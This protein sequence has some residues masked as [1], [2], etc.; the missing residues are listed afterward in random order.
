MKD[1]S[2]NLALA[3]SA[4]VRA[5]GTSDRLFRAA[6]GLILLVAAALVLITLGVVP[7]GGL[8]PGE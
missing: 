5:G 6:L 4:Y 8:I 2:H 3:G 1:R 7:I